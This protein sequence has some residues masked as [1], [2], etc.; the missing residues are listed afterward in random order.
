[1]Y[2][3]EDIEAMT[4]GQEVPY[5]R[6][7][8]AFVYDE[9]GDSLQFIAQNGNAWIYYAADGS[10]YMRDP[11]Y[12]FPTHYW[13]KGTQ[14]DNK[15]TVP[16]GQ[17]IIWTSNFMGLKTAWGEMG[18]EDFTYDTAGEVTYT[19]DGQTITLDN[20]ESSE[21]SVKGLALVLDSAYVDKGWYGYLDIYTTYIVYPD[22]PENVTVTP[23]A[24]TAEV[25]WTDNVNEQWN[26]RYREYSAAA[27]SAYS[28]DFE[29]SLE[30]WG[31]INA[32]GDSGD[33]ANWIWLMDQDDENNSV[34]ASL[35]YGRT[36]DNWMFAPDM[37]IN[38]GSV[39]SLKAWSWWDTAGA[40]EET[41]S[42]MIATDT[43]QYL[44]SYVALAEDVTASTVQVYNFSIPEEYIGQT[45]SIVIRHTGGN[46]LL[47]VDDFFVGDPD[48][49]PN[50]WIYVNDITEN[51]YT[52]TG[53]TP[54]TTYELNVQAVNA[55]GV[56]DWS[57]MVKFTT[58]AEG[59]Y[60]RGDVDGSG[61]VDITDA[62]AL[63]NYLLYGNANPFVEDNADVDY[64]GDIDISDATM[65]I[66]FLLYG[67]WPD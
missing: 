4:G 54:E 24:T 65:L 28:N 49:T 2:T 7:G 61:N 5:Y 53:L 63:I 22:A 45:C 37:L 13:V 6:K 26:I 50:P 8:Y 30:G 66:N 20:C 58:L 31:M 34:I 40:S 46:G 11:V 18:E 60:L 36:P 51:P 27:S 39:I 32:D 3:D 59:G 47:C 19:I 35:S 12:G 44:S 33:Y 64:S 42:I 41:F 17:Y 38:E 29:D 57:E 10:V 62:T 9:E 1:M 23:A 14:S 25:A 43:A 55:G 15:I 48:A 52:L 67:T 16:L 21:T 56:G